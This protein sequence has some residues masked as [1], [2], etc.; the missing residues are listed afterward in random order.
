MRLPWLAIFLVAVGLQK[1]PASDPLATR[2]STLDCIPTQGTEL[3]RKYQLST[4]TDRGG[5]LTVV[6]SPDGIVRNIVVEVGLS[7]SDLIKEFFF[8]ENRLVEVRETRR[9]YAYSEKTGTFNF[10]KVAFTT[11][12]HRMV[13]PSSRDKATEEGKATPK[14]KESLLIE[15]SDFFLRLLKDHPDLSKLDIEQHLKQGF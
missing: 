14:N 11:T 1:S 2:K 12:F 10:T 9:T 7:N 8:D 3:V 15:E 4:G 5:E 6:S 13:L